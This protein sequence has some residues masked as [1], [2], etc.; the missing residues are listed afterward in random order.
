MRERTSASSG[1]SRCE[2]RVNGE[3]R[4]RCAINAGRRGGR[5]RSDSSPRRTRSLRTSSRRGG[6]C[7]CVG[8]RHRLTTHRC[9]CCG[10][11]HPVLRVTAFRRAPVIDLITL[12]RAV[13]AWPDNAQ[14]EALLSKTA[15]R[16]ASALSAGERAG[17]ADIASLIR[18]VLREWQVVEHSTRLPSP[19]RVPA[20]PP[21]P[22]PTVWDAA[23]IQVAPGQVE[24]T[25][26]IVGVEA[27]APD[28]LRS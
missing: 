24:G 21:W 8:L 28:W 10:H 3:M 14:V 9:G 22:D 20:A 26:R 2:T 25:R 16:L 18:G 13:D 6:S 4:P 19:L 23:G 17:P 12:Q 15:P 5:C 7:D 11:R 27:W 1:D